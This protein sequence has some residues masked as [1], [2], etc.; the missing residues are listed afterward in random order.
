[1]S[2]VDHNLD[3]SADGTAATYFSRESVAGVPWM[4]SNKVLMLFV[5]MGLSILTVRLLGPA[6]YGRFVLARSV[7]EFFAIICALGL[8]VAI[9]RF[10]PELVATRNKAGLRRFLIRVLALQQTAALLATVALVVARPLLE[11]AFKV[12]FAG[13]LVPTGIL[14]AATIFKDALNNV[15]TALFRARIVAVFSL[16]NGV[17]WIS[18]LVWLLNRNPNA[19]VALSVQSSALLLVYGAALI[20]LSRLIR[21]LNWRS[22]P[23]GIGRH[24]ALTLSLSVMLNALLRML[25][26]KYT[27]VFFLGIYFTP[28]IVGYYDLGYS[29]PM[30]VLTLIPAALQTLL[31]SAFA[32]A[33]ARDPQCLGRLIDSVYKLTILIVLPLAAFGVFF[34][35]RGIVLLYGENM[36]AAGP[37][38]AAFCVLHVLPLISTPLS[39]AITVK[40]QVSRMLPYMLL[41]I[42]LNL[43]L[44]WIL[45]P[46]YGIAGAIGAVA[47]T[48]VL[49][50]PWRLRAVRAVLGGIH[51]PVAFFLRHLLVVGALAAALSPLAPHLNLWTLVAL[52]GTYLAVYLA[53][54][55][56]L[57]LIR[58]ED[59]ADLRS[60]GMT[61]ANQALALFV[62]RA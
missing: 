12:S 57:R 24:R 14:L 9:L 25:M 17:L 31:T 56:L 5:Y 36:A 34:A 59:V 2:K 8:D 46:R 39:M 22:P 29:T 26:L 27:E 33:Y 37:I 19:S 60:M 1:M 7:M 49:T 44:D 61:R 45:I 43:L 30:L 48:F 41:Q 4:V 40:E 50:I 3:A 21:A 35:S 53:L 16:L 10:I 58:P 15:F 32:Q 11:R 23:R 47:G 62:G 13:L 20:L 52:G 42:G 51:F 18:L 38:A 6:E 54:I 55:R 28:A